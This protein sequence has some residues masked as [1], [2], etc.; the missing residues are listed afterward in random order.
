ME[1]YI[2]L[3]V[4][5]KT[6]T[7]VAQAADGKLL[8][9]G[10]VS[11]SEEGLRGMRDEV[12]AG[13]GTRV[14]LESGPSA[15]QAVRI[16]YGL[17]LEPVVINAAEVRAKARRPNQK[18]DSRDA[19][20]ICDGLRRDN[21]VSIVHIPPEEIQLLRE[22]LAQRRHFV[23]TIT[24]QKNAV[25]SILRAKGKGS[26]Y[27][28]LKSKQ[29]WEKL[30]G[31]TELGDA[32]RDFVRMHYAIWSTAAAQVERIEGRIVELSKPFEEAQKRLTTIPGVGPI[33][34]L[35]AVAVLSSVKRFPTVKHA[36]S[37][38]GLVPSTYDSG[39]KER[40]GHI[41]KRG[42]RELR[43]M[44]VEAAQHAQRPIHPLNPYFAQI[45]AQKGYKIA[46]V[47]V[48]HRLLR[49]IVAMLKTQSDFDTTKLNVEA[50]VRK[51]TRTR[52]WER[53]RSAA[54]REGRA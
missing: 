32:V 1:M 39:E 37:Y 51:T 6:T 38:A 14:G 49:I 28:S 26:A 18:S 19:F 20:E 48:A 42:S 16:L 33:T 8:G 52:Y 36:S 50:K 30:L 2:G 27:R 10:T 11:T 41:T 13:S 12:G 40:H 54:P 17:G 45:A 7:F 43:A 5:H 46:V 34:A 24:G 21:Y 47:A 53:K 35:T 31:L 3:D 25:K 9:R 15:V 29:A 23:R 22:A 4:H 44:L